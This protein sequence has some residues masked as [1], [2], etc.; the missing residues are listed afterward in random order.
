MQW[1]RDSASDKLFGKVDLNYGLWISLATARVMETQA[2][3]KDDSLMPA[4]I[5]AVSLAWVCQHYTEKPRYHQKRG[6]FV[7]TQKPSGAPGLPHVLK[8]SMV[9]F[10]PHDSNRN[11]SGD[12]KWSSLVKL[13]EGTFFLSQLVTRLAFTSRDKNSKP[14]YQQDTQFSVG[15]GRCPVCPRKKGLW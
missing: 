10:F 6:L 15:G 5:S 8:S 14:E 3:R 1:A 2:S 9:Y 12:E 13:A 7:A 11:N 4:L